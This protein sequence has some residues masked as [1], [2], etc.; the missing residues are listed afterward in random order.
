MMAF[1]TK[2]RLFRKEVKLTMWSGYFLDFLSIVAIWTAIFDAAPRL[3]PFSTHAPVIV[4]PPAAIAMIGFAFMYGLRLSMYVAIIRKNRAPQIIEWW[5]MLIG[6]II[7]LVLWLF[8]GILLDVYAS[9]SGY[10][11][12]HQVGSGR[13]A[14]LLFTLHGHTCPP[15]LGTV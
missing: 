5:F 10:I 7:P 15:R 6:I 11:S 12:C 3:R 13:I 14:N 8:D 2:S 4:A 9:F 1:I